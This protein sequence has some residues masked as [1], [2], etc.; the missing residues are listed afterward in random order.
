MRRAPRDGAAGPFFR[1]HR[2]QGSVGAWGAA[3]GGCAAGPGGRSR[4]QCV[5]ARQGR[6]NCRCPTEGLG[7]F[8][9]SC[10]TG[11]ATATARSR[12]YSVLPLPPAGPGRPRSRPFS[13]VTGLLSPAVRSLSWSEVP[14]RTGRSVRHI[15]P[16]SHAWFF[17]AAPGWHGHRY[18]R[19]GRRGVT[20][21][22]G[23]SGCVRLSPERG[24]RSDR[25]T[26]PE[27]SSPARC[28]AC[29][30]PRCSG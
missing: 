5:S 29:P 7:A 22:T 4:W 9:A 28:P 3:P 12:R 6:G 27:A 10:W 16:A 25:G 2:R 24:F 30:A 14:R 15:A 20:L 13:W 18:Q 1:Q 21:R 11:G 8:Y 17:R 19:R 23:E 26:A